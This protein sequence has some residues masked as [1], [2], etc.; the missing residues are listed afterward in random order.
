MGRRSSQVTSGGV[1]AS[2][3]LLAADGLS[4]S[5]FRH[6]DL[7]I[8]QNGKRPRGSL[9]RRLRGIVADGRSQAPNT[10]RA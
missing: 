9:L 3:A 8:M 5:R 2:F 10:A 1:E 7:H 6:V 4:V